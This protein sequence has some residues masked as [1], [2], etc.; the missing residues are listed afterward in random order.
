[1]G[2]GLRAVGQVAE[3]VEG[4]VELA[5]IAAC[6]E[7]DHVEQVRITCCLGPG[8]GHGEM[9]DLRQGVVKNV[10]QAVTVFDQVL[11]QVEPPGVTIA[12]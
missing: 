8:D 12:L 3:L 6:A 9:A 7:R 4:F 2:I 10:R 11:D 1:M 5:G